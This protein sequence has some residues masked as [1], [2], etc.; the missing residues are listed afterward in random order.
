MINEDLLASEHGAAA[1]NSRVCRCTVCK[2]AH[3]E[4]CKAY[5][6]AARANARSM[7]LQLATQADELKQLRAFRDDMITR[8]L[9][10]QQA[11]SP[12]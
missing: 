1:Y 2:S 9:A 12:Q 7:K 11:V 3:N 5:N 4:A 10:A 6:K 8:V